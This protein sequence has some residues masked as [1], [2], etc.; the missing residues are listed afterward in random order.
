[1]YDSVTTGPGANDNAS[2]A[3][4]VL[5]IAAVIASKGE[6]GANCFVLFG[7]EERGLRGSQAF[8]KSLDAAARGRIKAMLN[9]DM[10]GFGQNATIQL[11]GSGS[12]K[13]RAFDISKTIDVPTALSDL[14][15]TTSSD[16]A[17]FI[18]AGISALMFYRGEDPAWHRPEDTVERLNPAYLE[19]TVR[20]GVA[21]LES[22][23][24]GGS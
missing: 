11:I 22:L 24:A 12:L 16:H 3:A 17:V 6:T 19:A 14:P 15:A 13:T 10:V 4:S 8:V 21:V 20:L 7:A 23:M 1:H 9:F 18:N 5:E 2:G